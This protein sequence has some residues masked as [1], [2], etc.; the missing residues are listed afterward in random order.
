MT[1]TRNR[2]RL[3]TAAEAVFALLLVVALLAGA[4]TW[5]VVVLAVLFCDAA[6]YGLWQMVAL[7][8]APS[9]PRAAVT[10]A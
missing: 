3:A 10:Q 5:E 6:A 8:R 2:L 1:A 7:R 9:G 4:P